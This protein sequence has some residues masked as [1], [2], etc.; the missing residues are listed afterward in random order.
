MASSVS[1]FIRVNHWVNDN[2]VA[3]ALAIASLVKAALCGVAQALVVALEDLALFLAEVLEDFVSV[4]EVAFGC[5]DAVLTTAISSCL[6]VKSGLAT[7]PNFF[8]FPFCCEK[9]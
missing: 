5:I 9:S 3:A 6:A 1:L 7:K 2:V 8:L 4:V